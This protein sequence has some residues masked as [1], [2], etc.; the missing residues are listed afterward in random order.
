MRRAIMCTF[1]GEYTGS[2]LIYLHQTRKYAF[3]IITHTKT[4]QTLDFGT[5]WYKHE[6]FFKE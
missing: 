4:H 2:W 6:Y 3:A 1:K 5:V